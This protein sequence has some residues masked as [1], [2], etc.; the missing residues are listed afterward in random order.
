MRG[1]L[2]CERTLK[3]SE[4][5]ESLPPQATSRE[6][7]FEKRR[8]AVEHCCFHRARKREHQPSES[9]VGRS[10]FSSFASSRPSQDG[11]A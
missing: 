11:R 10:S 7:S 9:G 4:R 8:R 1:E 6:D 2:R 5:S 3:Q